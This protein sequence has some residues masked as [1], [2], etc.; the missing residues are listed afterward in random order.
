MW[1]IAAGAVGVVSVLA[2]ANDDKRHNNFEV[3]FGVPFSLTR[4]WRSVLPANENIFY[5]GRER[6]FSNLESPTHKGNICEIIF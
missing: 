6:K 4:N 5:Q 3:I 1:T 2:A